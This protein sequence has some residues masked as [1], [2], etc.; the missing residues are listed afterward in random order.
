MKSEGLEEQLHRYTMEKNLTKMEKLLRKGVDVDCINH[1]GQTPLFCAALLGHGAVSELLLQYRADPNHGLVQQLHKKSNDNYNKGLCTTA[2][3]FGFG[4]VCMDRPCKALGVLASIPLIQ[5]TDL[6]QADD[7]TLRS[8]SCGSLT[9]MTN[10]SWK[11]SRVTVKQIKA[12]KAAYKD[13][14]LTEQEYCSQ[15]FHPHLLQL[16]AVSLS[17]DLL[18]TRLVFERVHVDTLHNLLHHKRAEFPVLHMAWLLPVLLQVC[19][20]VLY[21]HSRGLVIRALSSHSVVLTRPGLAKLTGFGFMVHR[22][23]PCVKPSVQLDVPP[24]FY[25]WAAPE[26]IRRRSCTEKA[27]LYSLCTIIQEMYTDAVPWGAVDHNWIK[28]VVEGGEALQADSRVPEPFYALICVG[29][30]PHATERTQSVQDLCVTLR[31]DIKS[32]SPDGK[33]SSSGD[34]GYTTAAPHTQSWQTVNEKTHQKLSSKQAR[35]QPIQHEGIQSGEERE[36]KM[37]EQVTEEVKDDEGPL[38]SVLHPVLS[39]NGALPLDEWCV[40]PS[41][42]LTLSEGSMHSESVEDCLE[43]A[44]NTDLLTGDLRLSEVRQEQIGSIVLNLKVSQVLLQQGDASLDVVESCLRTRGGNDE[45][46]CREAS[47]TNPSKYRSAVGPPSPRYRRPPRPLAKTLERQ[48]HYGERPQSQEREREELTFGMAPSP[49][50]K[51]DCQEYRKKSYEQTNRSSLINKGSLDIHPRPKHEEVGGINSRAWSHLQDLPGTRK[52]NELIERSCASPDFL[53]GIQSSLQ[54]M[55]V[56]AQA[57]KTDSSSES[58]SDRDF[59]TVNQ[60]FALTS[61]GCDDQ[62]PSQEESNSD[63]DDRH[64]TLRS[65]PTVHNPDPKAT[66]SQDPG[67]EEGGDVIPV[68]FGPEGCRPEGHLANITHCED[69]CVL[70]EKEM[71]FDGD[72]ARP[73]LSRLKNTTSDPSCL[74]QV[75]SDMLQHFTELAELSSITGSPG[76][77]QDGLFRTSLNRPPP[78]CNSTPRSLAHL[79]SNPTGTEVN[80]SPILEAPAVQWTS[81]SLNSESFTTAAADV[82]GDGLQDNLVATNTI[83]SPFLKVDP[84]PQ[85]PSHLLQSPDLNLAGSTDRAQCPGPGKEQR[86]AGREA[87]EGRQE[88]QHAEGAGP[89]AGLD[90][91][92]RSGQQGDGK[93]HCVEAAEHAGPDHR[94]ATE[95]SLPG[96]CGAASVMNRELKGLLDDDEEGALHKACADQCGDL[97]PVGGKPSE[98]P[99]SLEWSDRAHST[100]DEALADSR[101]PRLVGPAGATETGS[102]R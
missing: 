7:E 40:Y 12:L 34:W 75:D 102:P 62:E 47:P 74:A 1:L 84:G 15:L 26:V 5:E 32:L 77:H 17:A 10:Y 3:C 19:E 41:A 14:L 29:L 48:G 56:Q 67:S 101:T 99:S 22:K 70:S 44:K 31:S 100:L 25:N 72:S 42:P 86:G 79:K 76:Q 52:I 95:Q 13:L 6:T 50:L 91:G 55:G 49:F 65:C 11:G 98:D 35:Q 90:E 24:S 9:S 92:D 23:S 89:C 93:G 21:L 58:E 51:N 37:V 18:K 43:P 63:T 83:Q 28:Q 57:T 4:K 82:S 96:G 88:E 20:G 33:L 45:V 78:P 16:M 73:A 87:V 36:V 59:H 71:P 69:E 53:G 27:D 46:D 66:Q 81:M 61:K 80:N 30:Q 64:T 38:I 60:T 68:V 85:P 97:Q 94:G 54:Q 8:F 2:Q 39:V